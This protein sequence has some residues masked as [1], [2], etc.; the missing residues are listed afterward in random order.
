LFA[1]LSCRCGAAGGEILMA[2]GII[3]IVVFLSVLLLLELIP[4]PSEGE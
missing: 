1:D 2:A 3:Q 4:K